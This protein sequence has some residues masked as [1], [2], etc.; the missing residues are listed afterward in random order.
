M[1]QGRRG[2]S[3][4]S[5]I[6]KKKRVDKAGRIVFP[7]KIELLDPDNQLI[8]NRNMQKITKVS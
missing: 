2:M 4:L 5:N 8:K 1:S 6:P 3:F 7:I